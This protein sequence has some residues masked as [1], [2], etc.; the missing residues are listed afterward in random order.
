MTA[1]DSLAQEILA[2]MANGMGSGLDDAGFDRLARAVFT[3]QFES[4]A[5]YRAFCERRSRT[6]GSVEH[7][8]EIPAVPTSAFREAELI[9]D[10][11]PAVRVFETSGTTG[12]TTGKH[13][14]SRRG[15]ELYRASMVPP[16]RHFLMPELTGTRP[17]CDGLPLVLGPPSAEAPESSLYFMIDELCHRLFSSV[18]AHVLGPRGLDFDKLR[19]SLR[20]AQKQTRPV[21]LFGTALAFDDLCLRLEVA[22]ERYSLA[23]GSRIME[24]GGGKAAGGVMAPAGLRLRLRHSLGVEENAIVSEYGM[25]EAC[26]QFYEATLLGGA[27][28]TDADGVRLKFGPPW[29]RAVVCNPESL[30]PA[31]PGKIGVLRLVDLANRYSISF[32]QTEDLARAAGNDGAFSLHGRAGRAEARGCSLASEEWLRATAEERA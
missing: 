32:L 3:V 29:V 28:G 31:A 11:E 4:C 1:H 2:V 5:P 8:L 13:L 17:R 12:S 21:F 6:P 14:V 26:S 25:T 30:A 23:P 9:S 24:T 7:W 22:G 15:L 18:A 19:E 27:G 16:F 10:A 20:E